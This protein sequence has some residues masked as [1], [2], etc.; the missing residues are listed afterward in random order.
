V[1]IIGCDLEADSI[2]SWIRT[3]IIWQI[4]VVVIFLLVGLIV[5]ISLIRRINRIFLPDGKKS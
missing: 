4:G 2:I 3:Q 5:Y 1:G